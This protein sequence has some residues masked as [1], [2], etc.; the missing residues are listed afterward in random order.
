MTETTAGPRLR[1]AD[2]VRRRVFGLDAPSR[3]PE[4]IGVEVE[5]IPVREGDGTPLPLED[6]R[7][8]DLLTLLRDLGA[9]GREP[10]RSPGTGAPCVPVSGGGA[11]SLEPGGQ[12]EYSS[13]VG[14]SVDEA[15]DEVARA[16]EALR[17]VGRVRGIELVTRGIDPVTPEERA[18]LAVASGRYLRLARHLDRKGS[19]GRRMMLQT[20]AVHVNLDLGSRPLLR[21]RVANG[22]VPHLIALF[23]NSSRY[24]GAETGYRS[25]R[26]RQWQLLDRSRSG[27][28]VPG[29]PVED[30][31]AFALDAE[32]ILL[33]SPAEPPRPFREW[34][35]ARDVGEEAWRAHLSTL[36]PEVRPR[37]YLEVRSVDA[38]PPRWYAAPVVFLA[39]LLLD[40]GALEDARELVC[41]GEPPDL[42]GAARQGVGDP[43]RARRALELFDLALTGARRL[44][45]E[46]IGEAALETARTFRDRYTARGRDPASDPE[47]AGS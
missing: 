3:A 30:Y 8:P 44:G 40:D 25:Y 21:W 5:L 41:T 38:L 13:T 39:G 19:A 14:R 34:L 22:L 28:F 33:G 15:L 4:R 9:P 24:G 43:E 32:A 17:G 47:A 31:L 26:A 45:P 29:D 11:W 6:G 10:E 42:E 18:R 20:A 7:G 2:D 23:A 12:L 46:V 27:V 1:L 36:F 35:G 37:G 16:V